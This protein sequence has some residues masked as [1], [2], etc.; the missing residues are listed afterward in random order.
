MSYETDYSKA[1]SWGLRRYRTGAPI[2][3][4]IHVVEHALGKPIPAGAEVHHIDRDKRNFAPANLVL[5]E[6][7]AYHGLLHRRERALEGC[8]NPN[9]RI[10]KFC[11][12]YDAPENLQIDEKKSSCNHAACKTAYRKEYYS[13]KGR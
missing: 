5:C 8:G 1:G 7:H 6:D 3:T 2:R 13:R 10:C 12:Q 11:R 4:H 9:W